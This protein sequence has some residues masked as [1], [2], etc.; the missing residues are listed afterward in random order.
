M[1]Q[2]ETKLDVKVE[3]DSVIA[4]LLEAKDRL[5]RLGWGRT[6]VVAS[7]N[8]RCLIGA[9]APDDAPVSTAFAGAFMLAFRGTTEEGR[10]LKAVLNSPSIWPI[11]DV[12]FKSVEDAYAALDAAIALRQQELGL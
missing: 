10:L 4:K 12:V 5:A 1:L 6:H 11:N 8:K 9:F 2:Q 3:P 7:D